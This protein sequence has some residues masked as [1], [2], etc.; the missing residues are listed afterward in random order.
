MCAAEHDL[1]MVLLAE[2]TVNGYAIDRIP[3]FRPESFDAGSF[4]DAALMMK[5]RHIPYVLL[6]G[7]E[8]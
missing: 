2:D 5:Q 8:I 3:P 6:G 4:H 1:E 7:N